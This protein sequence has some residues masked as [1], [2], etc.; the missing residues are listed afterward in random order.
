MSFH[1]KTRGISSNYPFLSERSKLSLFHCITPTGIIN[2]MPFDYI[3][4][5]PLL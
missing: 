3:L 1:M 5:D 2:H 4:V